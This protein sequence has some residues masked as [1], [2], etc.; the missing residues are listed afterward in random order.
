[1]FRSKGFTIAFCIL[2][3]MIMT[4][5]FVLGYLL[6]SGSGSQIIENTANLTTQA[7]TTTEPPTT[8]TEEPTTTT[9]APTTTTEEPTTT[10]EEVHDYTL[11]ALTKD[12]DHQL[13]VVGE[14]IP[15]KGVLTIVRAGDNEEGLVFH[16]RPRFDGMNASGNLVNFSGSF[17]IVSKIYIMDNGRP[18]L[19]YKTHDDYYVTSSEFYVS[20]VPDKPPVTEKDVTKVV[21]FGYNEPAGVVITVHQDDGSHMALSIF[22]YDAA[23]SSTVPLLINLIAEY[24]EDGSAHFEYHDVDESVHTGRIT[25]G[26]PDSAYISKEITVTFESTINFAAGGLREITLHN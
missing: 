7:T 6:F 16:K 12:D 13:P 14:E 20:Y 10:T 18:F 2:A 24:D 23:N 26:T 9:E 22:D 17:D 15:E 19:M 8:T 11:R 1:M 3:L 4:L 25:F 5:M 21:S